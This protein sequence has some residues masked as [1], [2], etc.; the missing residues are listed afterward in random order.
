MV[1]ESQTYLLPPFNFLHFSLPLRIPG[2]VQSPNFL[3]SLSIFLIQDNNVLV[4]LEFIY[5]LVYQPTVLSA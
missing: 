5:L 3:A 2:D 4:N 1:V